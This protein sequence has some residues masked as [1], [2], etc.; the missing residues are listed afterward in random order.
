LQSGLSFSF[1]LVNVTFH[2]I[3]AIATAAVLSSR[4]SAQCSPI[5]D[6]FPLLTIGFVVGILAHGAL[7]HVPHTYPIPSALDVFLGLTLFL[8][9]IATSKQ[10]HRVL[11]GACFAGSVL[12]DLI[13]LGPAIINRRLGLSLPVVKI[14]PW[15]WPRYSGSIFDHRWHTSSFFA[16]CAVLG[17]SLALMYLYRSSL[18]VLNQ[19]RWR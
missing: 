16:H 17:V 19:Q 10:G 12:P 13:D 1:I 7:D 15:H 6:R 8:A 5:R 18:F 3:G 9:A 11:L 2:T 14:F 4:R